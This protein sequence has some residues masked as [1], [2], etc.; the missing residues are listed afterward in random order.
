MRHPVLSIF[1]FLLVL[2]LSPYLLAL[3]LLGTVL[4]AVLM[5]LAL[6]FQGRR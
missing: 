3:A 4:W 5:L 2:L 1:V 6:P